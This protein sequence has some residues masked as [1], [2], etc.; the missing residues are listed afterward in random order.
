MPIFTGTTMKQKKG[1]FF[2][3]FKTKGVCA[4]EIHFE[5][6]GNHIK[7]VDFIGGCDGNTTGVSRLI[8][9]MDV[10]EAISRLEGITCGFKKTSCP[11]Q[12]AKALKEYQAKN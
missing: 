1:D 4:T 9:G 7:N 12:L 11:D 8:E 3:I 5:V 6:E 10:N 2:M